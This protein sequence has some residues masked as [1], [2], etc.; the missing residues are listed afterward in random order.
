MGSDTNIGGPFGGGG[1]YGYVAPSYWTA[2]TNAFRRRQPIASPPVGDS[3]GANSYSFVRGRVRVIMLDTRSRKRW[4]FS[5]ANGASAQTS[6]NQVTLTLSS[7]QFT[8]GYFPVPGYDIRC[9]AAGASVPAGTIITNVVQQ[10]TSGNGWV[11]ILDLNNTVTIP[12]SATV[13]AST[14]QIGATQLAWVQSELA[15]AAS[16]GQFVFIMFPNGWPHIGW[17]DNYNFQLSGHAVEQQAICDSIIT[18]GLNGKCIVFGGDTHFTCMDSGFNT[19]YSTWGGLRVPNVHIC[20]FHS[21]NKSVNTNAD[22]DIFDEDGA[23][24]KQS[25]GGLIDVVDGGGST[26]TVNVNTYHADNIAPPSS[27]F[28]KVNAASP[29]FTLGSADPQPLGGGCT[30]R[31]Y[32]RVMVGNGNTTGQTW[33]AT[34]R[35]P[36]LAGSLILA[37]EVQYN[38]NTT[39][40]TTTGWT[41]LDGVRG[42]TNQFSRLYGKIDAAGGTTSESLGATGSITGG[43]LIVVEVVSPTGWPAIGSVVNAVAADPYAGSNRSSVSATLTTTQ[44]N[45]PMFGFAV[46]DR[47]AGLTPNYIPITDGGAGYLSAWTGG[48][49]QVLKVGQAGVY[50]ASLTGRPAPIS[51]SAGDTGATGARSVGYS[52]PSTVFRSPTATGVE[53]AISNVAVMSLLVV[54]LKPN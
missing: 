10:G 24:L 46:A 14:Q 37:W 32:A 40:G 28:A 30:I 13:Y 27:N 5:T 54:A 2:C 31:Q 29:T 39:P 43:T 34:F 44:A 33:T 20:A 49:Q 50:G 51:V 42:A 45:L 47:T 38:G 11:W 16:A 18:N 9:D 8:T 48:L 4:G 23:V 6:V 15:A 7:G 3:T 12:A 36:T 53:A 22:F 41:L 19:D 17:Q 25:V 35:Q 52:I 26:I 1:N 21:A